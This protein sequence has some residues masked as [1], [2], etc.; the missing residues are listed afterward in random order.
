[1]STLDK[2]L[3]TE[4]ELARVK[5]LSD[6]EINNILENIDDSQI[7]KIS[8]FL[9]SVRRSQSAQKSFN[10]LKDRM[11]DALRDLAD[12]SVVLTGYGNINGKGSLVCDGNFDIHDVENTYDA[13]FELPIYFKES[14]WYYTGTSYG[15]K[16]A[17]ERVRGDYINNG[18]FI[19]A[20]ILRGYDVKIGK[21]DVNAK[22]KIRL[23]EE[24]VQSE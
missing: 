7:H 19:M 6:S 21:K 22:V 24:Y 9:L 18:S 17:L 15:L 3:E 13:Y 10:E 5:G 16:H 12:R 11:Y 1:M 4:I 14:K 20:C 23:K 8:D 2:L